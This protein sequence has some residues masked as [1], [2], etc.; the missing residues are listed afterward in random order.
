MIKKLC[1]G[2]LFGLTAL[3]W[4]FPVPAQAHRVN[5]F[6]LVERENIVC[7][8]SFPDGSAVKNG[9][10]TVKFKGK[11]EPLLKTSINEQGQAEFSIPA[12]AKS[13]KK[14]LH[15]VLEASMGHKAS[16]TVQSEELGEQDE[17]PKTDPAI[18]A[19]PEHTPAQDSQANQTAKARPVRISLDREEVQNIVAKAVSQEVA[20]LKRQLQSLQQDRV[21]LQDILGGLGYILGLMGL[22][23]YFKSRGSGR[24]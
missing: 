19:K 22:T 17:S 2:S 13:N 5:L 4:L 16:W 3:S 6:C 7:Q 18:E 21:S 9:E 1:L 20:P 24:R 15:I 10:I 23:F 14:D 8:G 11:N 12:Q